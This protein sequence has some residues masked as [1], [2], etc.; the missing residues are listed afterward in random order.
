M[1][2]VEKAAANHYDKLMALPRDEEVH[3][4]NVANARARKAFAECT[5]WDAAT[6]NCCQKCLLIMSTVST[7]TSCYIVQLFPAQ[8]FVTFDITDS[9]DKK[10]GGDATNLVKPLGRVAFMLFACGWFCLW[11]FNHNTSSYIR[12]HRSNNDEAESASVGPSVADKAHIT[13][14]AGRKKR[15]V[16]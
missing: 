6:M 11:L 10:L 5:S 13:A 16:V 7:V 4:R 1:Y 2:F 9:I 14:V 12:H 3:Q 8:C 15:L